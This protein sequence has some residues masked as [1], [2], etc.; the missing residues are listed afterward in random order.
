MLVFAFQKA[1]CPVRNLKPAEELWALKMGSFGPQAQQFTGHWG[2]LSITQGSFKKQG[3]FRINRIQTVEAL[4]LPLDYGKT[5]LV[6]MAPDRRKV[7][8]EAQA[9]PLHWCIGHKAQ[10][11]TPHMHEL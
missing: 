8:L 3:H 5:F 10:H 1:L 2:T 11:G 4:W 6:Q 9:L 7:Q